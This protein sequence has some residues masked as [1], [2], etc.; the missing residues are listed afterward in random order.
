MKAAIYDPAALK[1]VLPVE[2]A[3]YLR[4]HGWTE[5]RHVGDRAVLW[6]HH[7]ES[8]HFDIVMPLRRDLAD[9]ETRIAEALDTLEAVEGRSQ[10]EIIK[11]LYTASADVVRVP[12]KPDG[13]SSGMVGIDEGVELVRHARELVMAA[14]CSADQKRAVFPSRKP[15]NA[16]N[17]M[18]GAK[19][20]QTEHGSYVITII[21]PVSTPPGAILSEGLV[22][23]EPFGRRVIHTLASAVVEVRAAALRAAV[24]GKISE[25]DATVRSGVSANLCDAIVGISEVSPNDGFNIDISWASSLPVEG[26]QPNSIR[27]PSD[28]ISI[29]KDASRHFREANPR[30][31]F[32]IEGIVVG[33]TKEPT[34]TIGTV[35]LLAFVDERPRKVSIDLSEEDYQLATRAHYQ[36]RPVACVGELIKE[37]RFL[38]LRL[39]RGLRIIPD[40]HDEEPSLFDLL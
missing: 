23:E 40:E 39:P 1:A 5:A 27:I 19:F 22:P 10:I 13:S 4:A 35:R 21:S 18:K 34:S 7:H 29:V 11:N 16:L 6:S 3:A 33:L 28:T 14:A 24:N 37:G 20:G 30:E 25:F 31:E 38:F 9:Y 15:N 32:E 26:K 12:A 17:Y 8:K 2:L 36:R